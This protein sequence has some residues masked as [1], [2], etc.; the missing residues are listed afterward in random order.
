M[1]SHK[2]YTSVNIMFNWC[3]IGII[4]PVIYSA[5]IQLSVYHRQ[6]N[7]SIITLIKHNI[8]TGVSFMG[9]HMAVNLICTACK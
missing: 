9:S 1:G 5:P 6:Y 4:L 7:H 8:N 2:T 3:N